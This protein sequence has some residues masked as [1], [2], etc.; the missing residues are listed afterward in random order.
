MLVGRTRIVV[1]VTYLAGHGSDVVRA[2]GFELQIEA[3][4]RVPPGSQF[5]ARL[6]GRSLVRLIGYSAIVRYDASLT[7]LTVSVVGTAWQ[8]ADLVFVDEQPASGTV[9]IGVILDDDG[10]GV[11]EVDALASTLFARLFFTT[12]EP[13][14]A[15]IGFTDDPDFNL[16]IDVDL[17]GHDS[18]AD[19]RLTEAQVVV[20]RAGDEF[21]RGDSNNDGR[22]D[23]SD[24]VATLL[25]LFRDGEAPGCI[26]AANANGDDG[27]DIGD[28]VY[29]LLFFFVG[30]P[31]PDK[32]FPTC[33]TSDLEADRELGCETPENCP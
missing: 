25:W 26:A 18:G 20:G 22:V 14:V 16:L 28:P 5:E 8:S 4:A 15:T 17:N 30:G 29:S 6:L 23:V 11:T 9:T 24:A 10:Q 12:T 33:G 7:L 27:V 3:P 32:P 2:Q 19:L 31:A 21:L 1:L 13:A